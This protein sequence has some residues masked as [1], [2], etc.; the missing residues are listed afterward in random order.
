MT[1]E[2]PKGDALLG[3]QSEGVEGLKG[4]A[5]ADITGGQAKAS[6]QASTTASGDTDV[7]SAK[8]L[9]EAIESNS[10]EGLEAIL[11]AHEDDDFVATQVDERGN[12][13]LIRAVQLGYCDLV[14][15]L[16]NS[17]QASTTLANQA[18]DTALHW[19]CYRGDFSSVVALLSHGAPI[20]VPGDAGNRPLHLAASSGNAK[21]VFAL[22]MSG[23]AVISLNDYGNK[24]RHLCKDAQCSKMLKRI[25]LGGEP[26]R[27]ELKKEQ[28]EID[29]KRQVSR[30]RA[31]PQ[32]PDS[33]PV[34]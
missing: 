18:G 16:L 12:T 14:D 29:K 31:S 15:K 22:I 3:P 34:Y 23:A 32:V 21:V 20:E 28:E 8:A 17:Q 25:E 4:T 2:A 1:V 11:S 27:Q 30:S 26:A 19:A 13:A 7:R 6:G 5:A 24:P 9:F 10:S 33:Q